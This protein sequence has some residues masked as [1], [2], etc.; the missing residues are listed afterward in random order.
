MKI[1]LPAN[2]EN[3]EELKKGLENAGFEIGDT[4]SINSIAESFP[5]T[6]SWFC[7]CPRRTDRPCCNSNTAS[8]PR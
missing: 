8:L 2:D 4:A 3:A 7:S 6:A 1:R 5:L